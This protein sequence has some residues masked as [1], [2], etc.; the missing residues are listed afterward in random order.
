ML[1]NKIF[2]ASALGL[3][4]SK[5]AQ[6]LLCACISAVVRLSISCCADA[7]QLLCYEIQ[8]NYMPLK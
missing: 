2:N 1:T 6:Q 8:A 7:H 4:I 3:A 5:T